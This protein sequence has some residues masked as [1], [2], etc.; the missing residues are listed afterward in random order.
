M[1][2]VLLSA[3]YRYPVKSC[4]GASLETAALDRYGIAGDRHWMLVDAATG[5]FVTQ[6]QQARMALI[7]T[8]WH[9]D[10]LGLSAHGAGGV[11]VTSGLGEP[12]MVEV[13]GDVVQALDA[14]DEAAAWLSDHLGLAVRLVECGPGHRRPVDPEY[15]RIG[16]ETGFSDGFP[17]LLL[18]EASLADLNGRMA[19]PVSM[20]RFRPN[21]VVAGCAP[22]AEDGWKRLRIG[23]V[24]LHVVKPCSR[25][26]IP[27]IDPQ[28]A[29]R[30]RE[31]MATLLKYRRE[32]QKTYF[33]QNV[34][35][36]GPGELRIG[37]AVEVLE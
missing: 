14:G 36:A 3:L 11:E 32:G 33:G 2:D 35:H 17:L 26:P 1:A 37:M 8:Q 29:A 9:G 20:I 22:Y 23:E 15:D 16:A 6:R 21:L 13:W 30:G 24:E 5:K 31:P 7:D 28:T 34:I 4:R 10:T 12:R 27:T 25:C 19:A 18:S